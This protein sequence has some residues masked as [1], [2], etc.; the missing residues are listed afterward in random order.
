MNF[1]LFLLRKFEFELS[2]QQL[3]SLGIKYDSTIANTYPILNINFLMLILC[4]FIYFFKLLF[5]KLKESKWWSCIFKIPF[6]ITD[7]IFQMMIFSYFIRNILESSQFI[8]I[9]SIYEINKR[10]TTSFYRSISLSFSILTIILYAIVIIILQYLTFSSYKIIEG[11]HNMLEE[12]FRGLKVE[13]KYKFYSTMHFLRRAL[14]VLLLITWTFVHSKVLIAILSSVQL[15]YVIYLS[16]VRP[17]FEVKWN[18]IEILNEIYFGVLLA[19]LFILNTESD[20]TSLKTSIYMWTL[21]SNTLVVF[22]IVICKQ[23]FNYCIVFP[24]VSICKW[25]CKR[26]SEEQVS[27]KI[28]IFR[29]AGKLNIEKTRMYIIQVQET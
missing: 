24:T 22:I 10:N 15:A 13:R 4:I 29:K 23:F 19:A 3:N 6:W 26:W 8:L 20:W 25:I 5:K 14:F 28:I 12:F 18:L 16:W 21:V 7:K 1:S 27:C 11:K 17:Y 2:D 9:S